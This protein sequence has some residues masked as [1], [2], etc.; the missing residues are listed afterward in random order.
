MEDGDEGVTLAVG[1]GDL[2]LVVQDGQADQDV[3][4]GGAKVDRGHDVRLHPDG[5]PV[6]RDRVGERAIACQPLWLHF[7]QKLHIIN[8]GLN[9]SKSMTVA[10]C[11]D[12]LN[13]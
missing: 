3:G 4:I 9:R 8:G 10:V 1:A 11:G 13:K 6:S 12:L 7:A 2:L 5:V